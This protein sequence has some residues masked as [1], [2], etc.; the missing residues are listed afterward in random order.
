MLVGV[1]AFSVGGGE[2]SI[3]LALGRVGT[4]VDFDVTGGDA[5]GAAMG[6]STGAP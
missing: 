6:E 3:D 1:N 4:G 5:E 2:A